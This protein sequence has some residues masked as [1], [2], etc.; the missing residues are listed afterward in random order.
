MV[1]LI[2][3]LLSVKREGSVTVSGVGAE[4]VLSVIYM[5]T[6]HSVCN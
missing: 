6:V 2:E 5:D 1:M 4:I 3:D